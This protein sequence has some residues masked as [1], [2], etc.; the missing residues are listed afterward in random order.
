MADVPINPDDLRADATAIFSDTNGA[1]LL[2]TD[3]PMMG[4]MMGFNVKVDGGY[5]ESRHRLASS[6][7]GLERAGVLIRVV[8]SAAWDEMR[9]DLLRHGP[10]Y[11]WSK[12]VI[13]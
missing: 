11:R 4:F 6:I 8:P 9:E 10:I 13:A 2:L 7:I 3:K 5:L 1:S 12:G